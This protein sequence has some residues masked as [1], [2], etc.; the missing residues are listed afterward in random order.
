MSY[1]KEFEQVINFYLNTTPVQHQMFLRLILD[2]I[3]V[4]NVE[5]SESLETDEESDVTFNGIFHQIN[6]R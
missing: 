5:T 6:V 2:K 4:F 3:S 1:T